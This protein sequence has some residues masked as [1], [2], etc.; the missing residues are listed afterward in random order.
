MSPIDI[1][2]YDHDG[3]VFVMRCWVREDGELTGRVR[4]STVD[5]EQKSRM[6]G[7]TADLIGEAR[8]F[9]LRVRGGRDETNNRES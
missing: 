1:E 6:L 9:L 8:A 4:W 5:G 7:G 3:G 2:S